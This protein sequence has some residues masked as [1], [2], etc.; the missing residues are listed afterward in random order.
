MIVAARSWLK[1]LSSLRRHASPRTVDQVGE[2][3]HRAVAR[4][5]RRSSLMSSRRGAVASAELHD[6]VVLLAVALE[7]RD[8]A[9]AEHASRACGRRLS[10]STP[11]VGDLVAVDVDAQLAAC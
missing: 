4:R 1:W 5:A 2:L 3:H 11:D 6:H 8:L 10:T 7:A 9:A